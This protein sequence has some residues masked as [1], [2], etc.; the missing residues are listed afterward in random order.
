MIQRVEGKRPDIARD[1][2][3]HPTAVVIGQVKLG[4]QS[5]V[6]PG[7]VIRGDLSPIV[8]GERTS[9]QDGCVLHTGVRLQLRIGNDAVVGHRA[10]LH[11]C[12]IEDGAMIGMGA[13]IMDAAK[14]GAH[15]IVGAGALVPKGFV[16]PPRSVV[17]GCPC[18]VVREVTD[19]EVA[20]IEARCERYVQKALAYI[21]TGEIL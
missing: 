15:S 16:V 6:W 11:S 4:K 3:V 2:Y 8:V 18:R 20:D 9:I 7:A 10:M 13:I 14:I 1:A 21:R 12:D 5:S 17:V 19:E